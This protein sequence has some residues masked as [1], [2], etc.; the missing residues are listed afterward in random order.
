[1]GLEWRDDKFCN[2]RSC[3]FWGDGY[4]CSKRE[5]EQAG[6]E[7]DERYEQCRPRCLREAEEIVAN[8]DNAPGWA[9][10]ASKALLLGTV[11]LGAVYAIDGLLKWAGRML[12]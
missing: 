7:I 12:P 6:Y 3:G 1:M 2:R 11:L 9:V 8:S 5:L 4:Y 10:I